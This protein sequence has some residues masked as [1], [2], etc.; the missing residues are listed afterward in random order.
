M[1]KR[2]TE[3]RTQNP[4]LGARCEPC[5]GAA[6]MPSR[7]NP[8]TPEIRCLATNAVEVLGICAYRQIIWTS[9]AR[10]PSG[11]EANALFGGHPWNY[12][13]TERTKRLFSSMDAL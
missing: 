1:Q 7:R 11:F 13:Y 6:S 12:A 4:V 9:H 2:N 5:G 3:P 8:G 10:I